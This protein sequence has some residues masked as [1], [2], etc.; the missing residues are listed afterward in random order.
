ME[1]GELA[2]AKFAIALPDQWNG[3]LLLLAHGFRPETAPL[4][5]DLDPYKPFVRTLRSEGWMVAL[6]SYRRNGMI[7][8]DGIADLESLRDYIANTYGEPKLG[9]VLGESMGGAIVTQLAENFPEHYRGIVAIGAALE[10]T[11]RDQPLVYNHKP[12]LPIIFLTNQSEIAE[13]TS[14]IAAVAKGTTLP[15]F[16]KVDRDG[17]V[18]VN[19]AEKLAAVHSIAEW[20]ETSTSP[21]D[22]NGTV[23][24]SPGPSQLTYNQDSS[25]TARVTDVSAVYGNFNVNIQVSDFSRL[26]IKPHQFF[27]FVAGNK[28]F[29]V[30]YGSNFG[31]VPVGDWVA[32]P[33]AEGFTLFSK[34]FNNGAAAAHVKEGDLIAIRPAK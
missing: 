9:F 31:D 26:R 2:G 19:D 12:Q 7:V 24:P 10:L 1:T 17:H 21:H 6:T 15:V 28:T 33:D 23:A 3:K 5:A 4:V 30:L 18:N 27:E 11:E 32:F 8:R 25:A 29:R 14:Y 22:R 16:W 34:N 20:A 13:P